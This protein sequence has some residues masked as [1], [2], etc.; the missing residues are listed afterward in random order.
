MLLTQ[1][2][3]HVS[4]KHHKKS[5]GLNFSGFS[6][7]YGAMSAH[8]GYGGLAYSSD[9]MYMNQSCWTAP[10]GPGYI[11]GWCDS[12]FQT[13]AADTR[14]T[15]LAWIDK[16]GVMES[17]D[18]HS[19][20]LRSFMATSAW[21]A[22]Q[23]WEITSYIENNGQ[24]VEKGSMEIKTTFSKAET[25]KFKGAD[26]KGVAAIAFEMLSYGSPGNS[27]TYGPSYGLQMCIDHL[28][29]KFSK[30]ADLK[31]TGGNLLTPYELHHHQKAAHVAAVSQVTHDIAAAH[32]GGDGSAA[33]HRTDTGYHSQLL[34]L[35]HDSGLTSQFH[36]PG[37]EH[38]M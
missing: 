26:W 20:T 1:G 36:L 18:C 3:H 35:G 32:S 9:F 10:G 7:Y 15:S 12:G 6:G 29:V 24:L 4:D 5:R 22:N 31:H 38:L 34:T 13:I 17:A 11:N 16:Y 33:H 37:V 19:F 14:E 25:F 2:V 21:S 23:S 8:D 27:C 30:K 28:K